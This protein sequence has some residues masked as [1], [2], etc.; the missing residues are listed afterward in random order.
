MTQYQPIT[1]PLVYQMGHLGVPPYPRMI[2]G[3]WEKKEPVKFQRKEVPIGAL[4]KLNTRI[5]K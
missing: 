2:H 3:W 1:N 4:A 5:V